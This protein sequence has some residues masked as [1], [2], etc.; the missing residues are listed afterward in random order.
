MATLQ[1][2]GGGIDG[3][4]R[5]QSRY[6][7]QELSLVNCELKLQLI[8]R[9]LRIETFLLGMNPISFLLGINP[10]S[11]DARA[12]VAPS[13]VAM[14]FPWCCY[15]VAMVLPWCYHATARRRCTAPAHTGAAVSCSTGS[16]D[17]E[18]D[19]IHNLIASS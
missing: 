17:L 6:Q 8:L 19:S 12:K 10:P 3:L 11:F 18:S 15:G 7:T 14:V 1:V 13:A 9:I 5:G 16:Q 4:A 2:V